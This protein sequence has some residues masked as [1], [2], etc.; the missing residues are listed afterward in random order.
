MVAAELIPRA[1]LSHPIRCSMAARAPARV[2]G[3]VHDRVERGVNGSPCGLEGSHDRRCGPDLESYFRRTLIERRSAG[4]ENE[5]SS[6]IAG[7]S[8]E[9]GYSLH[10]NLFVG[11]AFYE[12]FIGRRIV[13]LGRS[14]ID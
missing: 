11:H 10:C 6:T 3:G 13:P 2:V 12:K 7:K 5:E 1:I 9:S 4:S 14:V 8:R